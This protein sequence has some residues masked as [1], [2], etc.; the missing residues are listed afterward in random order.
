MSDSGDSICSLRS[1]SSVSCRSFRSQKNKNKQTKHKQN[2]N[3]KKTT[4]SRA[5]ESMFWK[6]NF[7]FFHRVQHCLKEIGTRMNHICESQQ[8]PCSLAKFQ[9]EVEDM[10]WLSA[11]DVG[12]WC[13]EQSKDLVKMLLP[14]FFVNLK[15][16][17][18]CS[19]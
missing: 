11:N 10:E 17:S 19:N 4:T 13:A 16:H 14:V 2:T 6:L 1:M 9:S 12:H 3:K 7:V 15:C 18:W 8:L 5:V